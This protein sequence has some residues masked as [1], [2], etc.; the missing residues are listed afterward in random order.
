MGTR[1]SRHLAALCVP[2][3]PGGLLDSLAANDASA[4]GSSYTQ[5]GP[6]PSPSV[7]VD[8]T[9]RVAP[10]ISGGLGQSLEV[11][12]LRP[13]DTA[14][15]N[16]AAELGWRLD[17]EGSLAVRGWTAPTW[18]TGCWPVLGASS[19]DA[20]GGICTVRDTQRVVV[21]LPY[22]SKVY[23]RTHDPGGD[24]TWS[25]ALEVHDGS[26]TGVALIESDGALLLLVT[27]PGNGI[28]YRST[29]GGDTWSFWRRHS[30][31]ASTTRVHAAAGNDGQIL[32]FESSGTTLRQYAST[33]QLGTLTLVATTTSVAQAYTSVY[34]LP[35]GGFVAAY[36]QVSTL[37]PAVR[38]LST[39]FQ[40][41]VDAAEVVLDA[42]AC[43][44]IG[45]SVE[46]D[47]LIWSYVTDGTTPGT[48]VSYFSTDGGVTWET[49]I[50][51]VWDLCSTADD[52]VSELLTTTAAGATY[53]LCRPTGS[54]SGSDEAMVVRLGGWETVTPRG[55]GLWARPGPTHGSY[56]PFELPGD[57]GQWTRTAAGTPTE[58]LVSEGLY[59]STDPGGSDVVSYTAST[60]TYLSTTVEL[61]LAVAAGGSGS[62]DEIVVSADLA[63]STND[64]SL[65]CRLAVVTGTVWVNTRDPNAGTPSK[66]TDDTAIPAGD[67]FR[68]R[69]HVEPSSTGGSATGYVWVAS[70]TA[71]E[72]TL[73]WSGALTNNT[74]TPGSSG[75]ARWGLPT[76]P[77]SAT[78]E[79]YVS[80]VVVGGYAR[81][82]L[83]GG[84]QSA[85]NAGASGRPVSPLPIPLH[86]EVADADGRVPWLST[87]SGP[88]NLGEVY[89]VACA[90]DYPLTAVLPTVEPSPATAWRSTST[91]EQVIAWDYGSA[92][93]LGDSIALYVGGA[94]FRAIEFEYHNGSAWASALSMDLGVDSLD[95]SLSGDCLT[96]ASS[97]TSVDRY[98][99]EGELV[100]GSVILETGGGSGTQAFRV[101]ANTSG[102]WVSSGTGTPRVRILLDGDTSTAD[103]SG[104]C[105]I[106]WPSGVGVVHLSALLR[107]RR[108]RVRIPASQDTP[109][110]YY[111]A[112]VIYPAA[113]RVIG[114][115]PSW[116]WSRETAPNVDRRRSR[117]GT[118]RVR[119]LGP[120]ATT[121]SWG[122]TDGVLLDVLRDTASPDYL[123]TSTGLPLTAAGDVPWLLRGLLEGAKGG[124][125]PV[126]ALSAVPD[127][128]GVTITDRTLYLYGTLTGSV[129]EDNVQGTEGESEFQRVAAITVQELV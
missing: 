110:G 87:T 70:Y 115:P 50:A 125:I 33:D 69:L 74:A 38:T 10:V 100:G 68:L 4:T 116:G 39:A 2:T 88:A 104:S 96:P 109:D 51:P 75:L 103:T 16:E 61:G 17:G 126:V 106:V 14:I 114:Q 71:T 13:G 47:G 102:S 66:S 79:I 105:T 124:E 98:L 64:Y 81:D 55:D 43:S 29:D 63:D 89:D 73:L 123:G 28:V 108:W 37:Y 92:T 57:T 77:A 15:T 6:R 58:S 122:W 129:R 72:W 101:R 112:G 19:P 42:A 76:T 1:L 67:R 35:G 32:L 24:G 83:G 113:I 23:V 97:T 5:T 59:L 78:A 41:I 49:V 117:Y 3:D 120:L 21:A 31:G 18:F 20:V 107:A 44:T 34:A 85:S 48:A 111:Q 45:L 91:A 95:Y 119:Q 25:S 128:S 84:I 40:P 127:T 7:P 99:Q 86:P 94:N 56:L 65:K 82:Q 54:T 22:A 60:S 62:A 36:K 11:V 46:A 27:D 53:L 8:S 12:T 121:L 80:Y 118:D 93:W 26:A 9:S 90:Y 52:Y 30:I